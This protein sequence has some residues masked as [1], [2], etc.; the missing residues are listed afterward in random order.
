ML[1]TIY[2]LTYF[3]CLKDKLVALKRV[4]FDRDPQDRTSAA[5]SFGHNVEE[6]GCNIYPGRYLRF[7]LGSTYLGL[8][9]KDFP[10]H[11]TKPYD[12]IVI[13]RSI[14]SEGFCSVPWNGIASKAMAIPFH[15]ENPHSIPH[16]VHRICPI[17]GSLHRIESIHGLAGK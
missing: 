14:D 8:C 5:A 10:E 6:S 3:L 2:C 7:L 17:Y 4:R 9:N 11:R 12:V 1:E 13:T 15:L 16:S